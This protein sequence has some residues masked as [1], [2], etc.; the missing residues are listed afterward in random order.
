MS[1]RNLLAVVL[2]AAILSASVVLAQ[3]SAK[4]QTFNLTSAARDS[5]LYGDENELAIEVREPQIA[6][7]QL[8]TSLTMGFFNLNTTLLA[9]EQL[10][11]KFTEEATYW[12]DVKLVGQQAFNPVIRLNYNFSPWFAL[13]GAFSLSVSE[14]TAEIT[15]RHRRANEEDAIIENDPPLEEFDPEHRSL[16][17]LGTGMN[18][19]IYPFNLDGDG[20]GRF[21]P[22]LVGGARRIW[23]NL[24]SS[25][26]DDAAASWNYLGG[27]GLRFIA[28]DLVS[29]RIQVAYNTMEIQFNP[30]E[31]WETFNEGTVRIPVYQVIQGQSILVEEFKPQTIN[32]LSWGLGFTANF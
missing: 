24:N 19:I 9:G 12:G 32:T 13:E 22:Y 21:H 27:L 1:Q 16:I 10:L 14:Y 11:Y 15:E 23:Y 30:S 8:E 29:I 3:A 5:A 6:G 18:A 31:S 4:S 25:Y 26:T 28:D 2:L 20:R 7:G 17:T